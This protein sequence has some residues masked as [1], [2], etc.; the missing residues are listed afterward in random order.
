MQFLSGFTKMTKL[1]QWL[2]GSLV[3]LAPWTSIVTAGISVG[4]GLPVVLAGILSNIILLFPFYV[5]V[6]FVVISAF[7]V[8]WRTYNFNDCKE[9]EIELQ[10]QIEEAKA[11]LL[12]KGFV[13]D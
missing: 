3:V 6:V 4:A 2:F 7:I 8:I 12:L 5:A 10:R 11:D 1:M 9:A 13:F